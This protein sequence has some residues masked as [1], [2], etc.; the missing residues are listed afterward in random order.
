MP[1]RQSHRMGIRILAQTSLSAAEKRLVIDQAAAEDR[2][3]AAREQQLVID[4][5]DDGLHAFASGDL[6]RR[7]TRAFPK[8]YEALR[9]NFNSAA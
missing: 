7:I 5:I 1:A 6:S 4:E 9:C 3:R 2:A 8:N